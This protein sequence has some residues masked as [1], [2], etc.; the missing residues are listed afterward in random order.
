MSNSYNI[1]RNIPPSTAVATAEN[2]K[3]KSDFLEYQLKL[4]K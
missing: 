2:I 3:T 4:L 1:S